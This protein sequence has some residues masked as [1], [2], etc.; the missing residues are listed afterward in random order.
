MKK[1]GYDLQRFDG[2]FSFNPFLIIPDLGLS[3]IGTSNSMRY[4][5]KIKYLLVILYL[6]LIPVSVD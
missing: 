2:N 6:N 1:R 3:L 4:T 5:M